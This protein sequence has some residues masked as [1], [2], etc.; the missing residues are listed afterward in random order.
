MVELQVSFTLTWWRQIKLT[1]ESARRFPEQQKLHNEILLLW[2]QGNR[3]IICGGYLHG[4]DSFG[5]GCLKFCSYA[6]C[7]AFE[8]FRC[9]VETSPEQSS[10]RTKLTAKQPTLVE[11]LSTSLTVLMRPRYCT[12]KQTRP[13]R[14]SAPSDCKLAYDSSGEAAVSIRRLTEV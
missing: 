2:A 8:V 4:R 10:Q 7:A 12:A 3:S 6:R 5:P 9:C 1:V 13:L 14:I 11:L